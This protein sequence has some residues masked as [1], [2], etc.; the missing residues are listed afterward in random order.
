MLVEPPVDEPD[1]RHRH[2]VEPEFDAVLISRRH[3]VLAKLSEP[4][5]D[6]ARDQQ[7]LAVPP[8]VRIERHLTIEGRERTLGAFLG[9]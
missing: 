4:V 8:L 3:T 9:R 2:V 1:D 5:F 6:V 7:P